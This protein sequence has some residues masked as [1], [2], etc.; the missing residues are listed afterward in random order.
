MFKYYLR[1]SDVTINPGTPVTP[2]SITGT[3]AQC[4]ALTAQTYSIAAVT[5]ATTYTWTVPTG[6]TIITGAGTNINYGNYRC[7]RTKW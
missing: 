6:W 3:V 4:P 2:G 7:S 1:N 5:N